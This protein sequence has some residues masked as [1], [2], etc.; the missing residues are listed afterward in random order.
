MEAA[1]G[2]AT[3]GQLT[4]G[5][6]MWLALTKNRQI[7]PAD[8][9]TMGIDGKAFFNGRWKLIARNNGELQLY[10]IVQDETESRNLASQQPNIVEKLQ[11]LLAAS[12]TGPSTSIPLWRV[13]L[14][15]DEF[16]GAERKA[17]IAD[18]AVE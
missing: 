13:I 10:D 18:L 4:D 3:T 7:A 16:G 6:S 14:D 5:K 9:I 12:P 11:G 17:P 8:F 15:P 1:T 2:D